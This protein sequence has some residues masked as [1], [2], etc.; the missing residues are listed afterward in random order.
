MFHFLN[1]PMD[2]DF[3]HINGLFFGHDYFSVLQV[4]GFPFVFNN[5]FNFLCTLPH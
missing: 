5:F 1:L 4:F 2:R 3:G